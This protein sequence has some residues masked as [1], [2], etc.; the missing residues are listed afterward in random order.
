MT[1]PP[2]RRGA[3][4]VVPAV[5][6]QGAVAAVLAQGAADQDGALASAPGG[7]WPAKSGHGGSGGPYSRCRAGRPSGIRRQGARRQHAEA[8][9][10]VRAGQVALLRRRVNSVHDIRSRAGR[11]GEEH[12]INERGTLSNLLTRVPHSLNPVRH[13]RCRWGERGGYE[14]TLWLPAGEAG[15][16]GVAC[17]E[18]GA[19]FRLRGGRAGLVGHA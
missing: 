3:Q 8:H 4:G 11:P 6:A 9:T 17:C 16:D 14:G 15:A 5:L 12:K 13:G 19:R 7:I 1:A 18:R 2:G 10:R